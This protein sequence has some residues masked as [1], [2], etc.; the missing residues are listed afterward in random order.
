MH[1]LADQ[2]M[3]GHITT[4]GG[5]PVCC[6][7]GMAA[8]DFAINEKLIDKVKEK[9]KRFR[10]KLIHPKIIEI[11]GIGLLLA[12]Q[13]DSF[14]NNKKI[15]DCCIKNGVVSD[16]FLF[17]DNAMRLAPPLII[18]DDEIDEACAIILKSIDEVIS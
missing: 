12:L 5:H 18:K 4:F 6:A 8:L 13:F 9:E 16:W 2:P 10:N 11:R 7:A 14:A 15:I 1:S 17:C 3:L